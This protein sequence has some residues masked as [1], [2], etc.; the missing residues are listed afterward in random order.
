M[1][2]RDPASTLG[3][4]PSQ[5][6]A[7]GSTPR[8]RIRRLPEKAV[9]ERDAAYAVLDEALLV[10]LGLVGD[11]NQPYVLPCG[12]ARDGDTLLLH[13]SS[14][15]RLFRTA[16]SGAPVCATATLLD[17]LVY[18]RSLFES[19]MH[20]RSVMVLGRGHSI[21]GPAKRRALQ[22]LSEKLLPGRSV[23]ARGPNTKELAATSVLVL[24]LDEISLK[25]SAAPPADLTEDLDR[26]IWAGVIPLRLVAGVAVDAPDLIGEHQVPDY[27]MAHPLRTGDST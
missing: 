25:V 18:A 12:H 16:S 21:S 2:T 13:G 26:P 1:P 19:S 15:S 5:L 23:D 8:T 14:G 7:P 17:G 6:P 24:P 20:Y 27:V 3:T 9:P 10:H 11:Q 4:P 22:V